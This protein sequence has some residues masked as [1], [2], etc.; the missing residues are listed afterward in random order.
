MSF[1][2]PKNFERLLNKK[3]IERLSVRSSSRNWPNLNPNQ[4]Q[5]SNTWPKSKPEPDINFYFGVDMPN[6]Y[7]RIKNNN[8]KGNKIGTG[9]DAWRMEMESDVRCVKYIWKVGQV[10]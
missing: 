3:K 6:D 10:A 5:N 2:S 8:N 7:G 9:G 1:I 4:N